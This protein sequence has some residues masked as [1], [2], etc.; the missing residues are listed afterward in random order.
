MLGRLVPLA[1][2]VTPAEWFIV[3][4]RSTTSRLAYWLSFGRYRHV[5]CFGYVAG[6]DAWLFFEPGIDDIAALVVP[7]GDAAVQAISNMVK[8]A[9]VVK[10]TAPIVFPKRSWR[11]L[12][13]CTVMVARLTGAR[14]C[15]LRPDRFLRDLLAEGAVDVA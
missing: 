6:V 12:F 10:L 11:P 8:G 14:S 3:F 4:R 13:V 7:D 5:A 2:S 1:V 15:A 9:R